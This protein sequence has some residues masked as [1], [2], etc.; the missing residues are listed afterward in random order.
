MHFLCHA[1]AV[2]SSIIELRAAAGGRSP[3]GEKYTE[4]NWGENPVL[5]KNGNKAGGGILYMGLKRS[6]SKTPL[7]SFIL[8]FL[9]RPPTITLHWSMGLLVFGLWFR[10]PF[11]RIYLYQSQL[12]IEPV[13]LN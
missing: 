10:V 13:I 8:M 7:F 5:L 2:Y 12:R 1:L 9:F 11:V 4:T 3:S 6:H